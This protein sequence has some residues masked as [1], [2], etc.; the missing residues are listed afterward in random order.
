MRVRI[1]IINCGKVQRINLGYAWNVSPSSDINPQDHQ[2]QR[3]RCF[4]KVSNTLLEMSYG[5][6]PIN[7]YSGASRKIHPPPPA[8]PACIV[9]PALFML[10]MVLNTTYQLVFRSLQK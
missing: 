2:V 9:L 10:M 7:L 8:C 1:F 6:Q 3:V 4:L 5:I